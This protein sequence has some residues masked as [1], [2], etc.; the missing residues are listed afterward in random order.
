MVSEK[1]N[2]PLDIVTYQAQDTGKRSKEGKVKYRY[3]NTQWYK[4][5]PW[6]H[7]DNNCGKLFCFY[8]S[9]ATSLHLFM[10]N[11][12]IMEA[13][14]VSQGYHCDWKNALAAFKTHE[15]VCHGDAVAAISALSKEG[16]D[17]KMDKQAK[18]LQKNASVALNKIITSVQF[19]GGQGLAMRGH[20]HM[21]GNFRKL[22]EMRSDDVDELREFLRRPK[23]FVSSDVQNEI[24]QLLSH[25]VLRNI[26]KN[27]NKSPYFSIIAD[28]TTDSG[29]MEQLSI[30]IRYIDDLQPVEQ[31]VG[32]YETADTSGEVLSS[33]LMD[34][35]TR[36]G[37][38]VTNLRGQC[39]DG[40][41]NMAG[42]HKGVQS[43]ILALQ[44]KALYV[45]C[46]AHTL[47]L[48]VQDAIR[49]VPICRDTL[50][51]IHDLATI[52]RSSAK[53]FQKF[54]DVAN[55]VEMFNVKVPKPLCPTRW[56]VRF[57]A[58]DA[59]LQSYNCIV[60]FLSEVA[61]MS[62]VDDSAAK[63]QGLLAQFENGVTY[64]ALYMMHG[65]FE[66]VDCLSC[67]LQA[68]DRT[69]TGALE[70]VQLT[71]NQLLKLRA[72]IKFD[73]L[74]D[75]VQN[76]ITQFDL[77]EIKLPRYIRRPARYEQNIL[78]EH[79]FESSRDYYRVQYFMFLD[80]VINHISQRFQQGGMIMYSKMESLVQTA[81]NAQDF[82]TLLSEV[83]DFYDDIQKSR[84]E[85]ELRMLP[86]IC[87]ASRSVTEAVN[88]FR[89][90]SKE[91]RLLF[92]E[93]ER[94]FHFLL[95]VPA[96]SS[97]AERSFSALKRLKSYLR[98][99]MSQERLNH[100]TLLHVHKDL[101]D[102]VH[103]GKI[104]AEFVSRKEYRRSVFGQMSQM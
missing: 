52:V 101:L 43:R 60:P 31:F 55:G 49:S 62:T 13:T 104:T 61:N 24:L 6:L 94:L 64:M 7:W 12:K 10:P 47:N 59:V 40:A 85:T 22:L 38:P 91:V 28:Q 93:V 30:C 58:I 2:Q 68:A 11:V 77:N 100:V 79:H 66:A 88:Q 21:D 45:H 84:L 102:S 67:V 14:F 99:T 39:Y 80:C 86:D 72:D 20:K 69:V 37:L 42:D 46:F 75:D 23:P 97:T 19:L 32:L 87:P 95:V 26:V 54:Q 65:V 53:R 41:A 81:L 73:V 1:P 103:I 48:S 29:K 51:V 16:I 18:E 27:I 9:K 36:L 44:P 89:T 17:S 70:S 92:K 63:S 33:V 5:Y 25:D 50:Q 71:I 90:K 82:S 98:T 4:R 8:C 56:T 83:S 57:A 74:W 96:S 15:G 76:K 3:F 78:N 34:V 35:L